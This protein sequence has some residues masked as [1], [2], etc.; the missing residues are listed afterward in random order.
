VKANRFITI[1]D[2]EEPAPRIRD[3]SAPKSRQPDPA[4]SSREDV[5][6]GARSELG[7]T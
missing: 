2:I 7:F 6:G 3:K 5:I 1:G 4:A